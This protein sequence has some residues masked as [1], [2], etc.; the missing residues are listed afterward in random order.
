MSHSRPIQ[1][2]EFAPANATLPLE[3]KVQNA[4]NLFLPLKS[5]AQMGEVLTL[6]AERQA[7]IDA[8]LANLRYV[9]FA[10]FLPS[11][12]FSTLWT[13]TTY[14]G[15]LDAYIMDFVAV[16]GDEFTAVLRFVRD[17]PPLPVQ[18]YPREFVH[19]V[20]THNV[21]IGVW[22]AYPELTAI[23]ILTGNVT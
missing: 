14:D 20:R 19:F 8:A 7:D 11:P 6:L 16:L 17:A 12:D 2:E 22:S 5:P 4:L 15:G 1:V 10:R 21:P 9:H 3:G 18:R 13:I 23:E